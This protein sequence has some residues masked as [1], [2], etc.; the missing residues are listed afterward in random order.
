MGFQLKVEFDAREAQHVITASLSSYSQVHMTTEEQVVNDDA[1][2]DN[3]G[4]LDIMT[5]R[6]TVSHLNQKPKEEDCGESLCGQ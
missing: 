6:F 5:T 2:S 1:I 4:S 3:G